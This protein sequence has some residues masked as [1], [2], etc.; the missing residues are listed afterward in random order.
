[1]AIAQTSASGI[2]VDSAGKR[3]LQLGKSFKC[4]RLHKTLPGTAAAGHRTN[5]TERPD[6]QRGITNASNCPSASVFA[7]PQRAFCCYSRCAYIYFSSLPF[8][9]TAAFAYRFLNLGV[10]AATAT[11]EFTHGQEVF[12]V[13]ALALLVPRSLQHVCIYIYIYVCNHLHAR[14][15]LC[16]S[17]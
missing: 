11:A 6:F 16:L 3:Q 5:R 14:Y 4:K 17:L 7:F 1:M 9:Q 15:S 13:I 12:Y 8:L 10:V 2:C